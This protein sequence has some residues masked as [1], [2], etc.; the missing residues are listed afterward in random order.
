MKL[1]G[2]HRRGQEAGGFNPLDI[3]NVIASDV[4]EAVRIA[5]EYWESKNVP[6][7]QHQIERVDSFQEI[8]ALGP[9]KEIVLLAAE[10]ERT[11]KRADELATVSRQNR[12]DSVAAVFGAKS[13]DAAKVL[14]TDLWDKGGRSVDPFF[15]WGRI[16]G[17]LDGAATFAHLMNESRTATFLHSAWE[18]ALA[19]LANYEQEGGA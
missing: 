5:I 1:Y 14:V 3:V 12:V 9:Q 16:A 11:L 15:A 8:H 4:P 18:Q 7:Q 19:R 17:Q 6:T 2:V 13:M 10:V